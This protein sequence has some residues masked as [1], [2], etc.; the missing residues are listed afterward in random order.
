[1]NYVNFE[2]HGQLSSLSSLPISILCLKKCNY[3][4]RYNSDTDESILIFFDINVAD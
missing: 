2:G 1:M 4:S 3:M